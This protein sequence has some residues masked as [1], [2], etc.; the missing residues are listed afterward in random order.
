MDDVRKLVQSLAVIGTMFEDLEEDN[1]KLKEENKRLIINFGTLVSEYNDYVKGVERLRALKEIKV[2]SK[3]ILGKHE[4]VK[5][6]AL[7]SDS[8]V[9]GMDEYVGCMAIVK[10]VDEEEDFCGCRTACVD[11]DQGRFV[12]RIENMTLCEE[13]AAPKKE[14]KVGSKVILGKHVEIEGYA[15]WSNSM[16]QYVGREACIKSISNGAPR[17]NPV[18]FVDIDDGIWCWRTCDMVLIE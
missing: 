8:W 5:R 18:A 14:I 7:E 6:G 15:D 16:D 4:V 3:V 1:K 17:G 13:E 12:W 2:G 10:R 9:A 11:I